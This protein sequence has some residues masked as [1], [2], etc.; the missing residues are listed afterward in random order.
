MLSGAILREWAVIRSLLLLLRKRGWL[1]PV[2]VALGLL[3]S[4]LEGVSLALLIPLL[5]TFGNNAHLTFGNS[6]AAKWLQAG[7]NAVPQQHRFVVI[8][9]G[10]L[11][12]VFLKNI[13]S[14]ANAA[15]FLSVESG[16]SHD[17]RVRLFERILAMPLAQTENDRSGRLMNL[18]GTETWRTSQALN[19]FFIAITNICTA[20]IFVPLLIVLSWRLTVIS[21]VSIAIVPLVISAVNGRIVALGNQT[22]AANSEPDVVGSEWA[23]GDSQFWT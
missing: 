14:Y 9:G 19:V 18:L 5:H 17:L 6:S 2:V 4:A 7:I 8:V 10:I 22:V 12:A 23:S 1:L 15:A 3:A 16:V 20:A 11:L 21:L 13:V